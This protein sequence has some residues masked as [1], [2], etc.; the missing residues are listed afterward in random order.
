MVYDVM[1]KH[2]DQIPSLVGGRD[3]GPG[4]AQ[5][6][7]HAVQINPSRSL[8]ATGARNSSEVAV[9]RLPTLDPVCLGEVYIQ[10][11]NFGLQVI[12]IGFRE[13]TET[14]SSTCAGWTISSSSPALETQES[15]SGVSTRRVLRKS[16]ELLKCR[17]T[18][19]FALSRS[20][21]ANRRRKFELSPTTRLL[22]K[23]RHSHSMASFTSG[24]PTTSSKSCPGSCHLVR[25]TCVWPCKTLACMQWDVDRTRCFWTQERCSLSKRSPPDTVAVVGV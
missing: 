14:G 2:L 24:M 15:P 3:T 10:I 1:S 12:K 19:R 23:L 21:S 5:C 13:H 25:R 22:K 8:L 17:T 7:I 11:F 9:Y 18:R 4:D 6:G 20:R 16:R